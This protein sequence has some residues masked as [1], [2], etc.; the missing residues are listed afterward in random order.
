MEHRTRA[1]TQA[2]FQ[3][4]VEETL[5]QHETSI[6]QIN[7]NVER[8]NATLKTMLADLQDLHSQTLKNAEERLNGNY[9]TGGPSF[10][11]PSPHSGMGQPSNFSEA[12][13]TRLKIDFPRF[14][15]EDPNGW[16]YRCEQYFK[17]KLVEESQQV[18][19][20]S[21][22]LDGL[23][24]Q[25]YHWL[26]KFRGPLTWNE[27]TRA[28]LH[29]FG[30]TDYDNP[31]E[32]LARLKQKHGCP[33]DN[34]SK[35]AAAQ[36]SAGLLGPPLANRINST[37]SLPVRRISAQEA[38]E[39]RSKGLCFYCDE[40]FVPGHRCNKPQLFMIAE[41]TPHDGKG[42]EMI[43]EISD[44][45]N[46]LPEISLHAI[47]RA[48]H[49]Q[50]FRVKGKIQNIEVTTLIDGGSTHNFMDQTLV[51]RLSLSMDQRN[52]LPVM[53]ANGDR[54]ECVGKCM[55]LTLTVQNCPV[56]DLCGVEQVT[57]FLLT[58][59]V[60]TLCERESSSEE[61]ERLLEEFQ[62]V[63]DTPSGLPPPRAHD[64]TIPL[65]PNQPLVD[66]LGHIIN[67][68]G[69][70]V[71]RAKI[72]AVIS[73]PR[74]TMTKGVRGFLGLAG[75]YRKFISGFGGIAAPLNKL[76]IPMPRKPSHV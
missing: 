27:F 12:N 64:H 11:K 28:V 14:N 36:T 48:T 34:I 65:L 63:F 46:S 74:P 26:G 19:L 62:R 5:Q 37:D 38:R 42:E 72:E 56:S 30:P 21:F 61:L 31:F 9:S 20:A 58:T 32:A 15:S 53:V 76:G 13:P 8:I 69:V 4:A 35:P 49:P 43:T 16:I 75:Y 29:R 54:I 55:G 67:S 52:K 73:W 66:Y 70:S 10:S 41:P 40:K 45:E 25:W 23:A 51:K 24:I 3:T 44:I 60:D 2:E 59:E 6:G 47:T 17:F 39:R 68:D 18:Q 1:V 71:D 33:T 7:T 57:C 50:T 22:H